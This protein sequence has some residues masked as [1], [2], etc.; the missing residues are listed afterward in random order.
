M[1]RMTPTDRRAA[2][3]DAAL[4]VMLRKGIAG[5]TARDVAAELG[6]SSGLIHHYFAS[7]DELLAVAFEL[8]A[9]KDL[10]SMRQAMDAEP[11]PLGKVLA[12]I[13][14]YARSEENWAFQL[15]LDAWSEAARRPALQ[16]ASRRLNVAWQQLLAS[17]LGA[18]VTTGAWHCAE[19]EASAWRL[20]S[21]L[22]GM[23]L[24]SV[25]HGE[26]IARHDV[27][28][29][30]QVATERELGLRA[31]TLRAGAAGHR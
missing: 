27:V 18:G 2:I 1:S 28:G 3:V 26:L 7:M 16:E 19:V 23:A 25:A 4:A 10:D 29:W 15:W 6:C 8:V 31:G 9:A 17:A 30:A 21:L 11:E 5:T 14:G 20:L 24:Q 13:S 22:D 12:F